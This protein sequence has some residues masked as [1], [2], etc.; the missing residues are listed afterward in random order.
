MDRFVWSDEVAVHF[1]RLYINQAK[2]AE[3]KAEK[4]KKAESAH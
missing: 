4:K 1:P 2:A 3:K